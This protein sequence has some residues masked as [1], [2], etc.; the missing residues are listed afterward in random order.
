MTD[1]GGQMTE[2]YKFQKLDVYQLALDY[3]DMVYEL[4]FE[5]P[6]NEKF[7]LRSQIQR[8]ATSIALNIVEGSTGQSDAEQGRF[9]GHALRSYLET[10]ACCDIALR[11]GYFEEP[12]LQELKNK[13][14]VLFMK[15][16]AFRKNLR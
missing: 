1:D 10:V 3:L 13:G 5:L 7:N 8:A 9:L 15:I 2:I 11:R 4:N 16:S 14:H 12:A 6:D